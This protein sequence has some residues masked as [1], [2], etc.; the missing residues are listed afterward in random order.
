MKAQ[1]CTLVSKVNRRHVA[2]LNQLHNYIDDNFVLKGQG[3]RIS[4]ADF[5]DEGITYILRKED[6]NINTSRLP[7][8]VWNKK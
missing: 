4:L 2:D 7:N 6:L 1:Q 8:V 5:R 3:N